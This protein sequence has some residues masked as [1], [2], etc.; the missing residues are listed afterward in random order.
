LA[1]QLNNENA[2]QLLNDVRVA[3][4]SEMKKD[5]GPETPQTN[6]LS[7]NI[8]GIS[9]SIQKKSTSDKAQEILQPALN[10]SEEITAKSRLVSDIHERFQDASTVANRFSDHQTLREKIAGTDHTKTVSD[11]LKIPV[12]DI[13]SA[14]GLS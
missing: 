3:V 1:L 8:N 7:E 12:K 14:I 5:I 10:P 6:A 9:Q 13:K 4:N 11:N 2:I